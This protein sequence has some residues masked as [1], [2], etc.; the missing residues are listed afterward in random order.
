MIDPRGLRVLQAVAT[1]G[2]VAAASV[3]DAL[4]NA[5]QESRQT[6]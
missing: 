5:R 4:A 1:H 3:L 6:S 2:S